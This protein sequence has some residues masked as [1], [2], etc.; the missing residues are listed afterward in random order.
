MA[1]LLLCDA[2]DCLA[3]CLGIKSPIHSDISWILIV[4]G[5]DFFPYMDELPVPFKNMPFYHLFLLQPFMVKAHILSCKN[6][7]SSIL[8]Q[9]LKESAKCPKNEQVELLIAGSLELRK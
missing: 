2:M 3:S 4:G 8:C 5:C 1:V 7:G 6:V 9:L